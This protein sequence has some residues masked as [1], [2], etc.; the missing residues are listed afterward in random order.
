MTSAELQVREELERFKT[1]NPNANGNLLTHLLRHFGVN[2]GIPDKGTDDYLLWY[3]CHRLATGRVPA[4]VPVRGRS[5]AAW[6]ADGVLPEWVQDLR[7]R[8]LEVWNAV[9]LHFEH[10]LGVIRDQ[11][12]AIQERKEQSIK[13]GLDEKRA[14][15][16]AQTEREVVDF[17]KVNRLK[18]ELHKVFADAQEKAETPFGKWLKARLPREQLRELGK[19]LAKVLGTRKGKR[20][21]EGYPRRK[22]DAE[23][24]P[25][26]LTLHF[27]GKNLNMDWADAATAAHNSYLE[28]GPQHDPPNHHGRR[29]ANGGNRTRRQMRRVTFFLPRPEVGKR[30]RGN[31]LEFSLD[32]L[33]HDPER[34]PPVVKQ[35]GVHFR[36][37]KWS[38]SFVVEQDFPKIVPE[39][40]TYLGVDIGWRQKEA[41]AVAV[42]H[43]ATETSESYDHK[44]IQLE[45]NRRMR[46]LWKDESLNPRDRLR[47]MAKEISESQN[48]MKAVLTQYLEKN[49]GIPAGWDRAGKR[50][51][52]RAPIADPAVAAQRD[53]WLKEDAE[54]RKRFG[55]M[56]GTLA[57]YKRNKYI[58]WAHRLC[59]MATDIGVEQKF[60]KQVA[61]AKPSK[62]ERKQ[63]VEEKQYVPEKHIAEQ[64]AANRQFAAPA[65]F[66]EILKW[67]AKKRGVR[68]HILDPWM[69]TRRCFGCGHDNPPAPIDSVTFVC[70]GCG[71]NWNQDE[72]AAMNLARLARECSGGDGN[73]GGCSHDGKS[74]PHH[75]LQGHL[76]AAAERKAKKAARRSQEPPQDPVAD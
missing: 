25:F 69:T 55:L 5:Y 75:G 76:E 54:G 37:G 73:R 8:Q 61:E 72:N 12:A 1:A 49:G 42:V 46:R 70:A 15:Q 29:G 45:R 26:A 31:N 62:A 66:V 6:L 40:R 41:D 30:E 27:A 47:Q 28:I 2:A 50:M 59:D 11:Y 64:A 43:Y 20:W 65:M 53:N 16:Q 35:A 48:A 71:R 52:S 44:S 58:E 21:D 17:S 56:S 63:R 14:E 39:T 34:L 3:H 4:A 32:V 18:K 33:V 7:V 67:V 22:Q 51:M 10:E 68:V 9:A 38:V 19:R 60:V 13:T 57:I 24:L 23:D 74:M 36:D